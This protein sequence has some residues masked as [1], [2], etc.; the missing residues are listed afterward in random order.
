MGLVLRLSCRLTTPLPRVL[1]PSGTRETSWSNH[2]SGT[3]DHRPGRRTIFMGLQTSPSPYMEKGDTP[4]Q[5]TSPP[6]CPVETRFNRVPCTKGTA[7]VSGHSPSF[8]DSRT[9]RPSQGLLVRFSGPPARPR[10]WGSITVKSRLDVRH[11]PP[12]TRSG[13]TIPA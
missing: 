12:D 7:R 8:P 2:R 6:T 9:G 3:E 4:F 1:V 11:T 10:L 13:V 5:W